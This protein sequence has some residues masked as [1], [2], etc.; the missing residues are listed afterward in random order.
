MSQA[1]KRREALK[2]VVFALL[3]GAITTGIISL[4]LISINLGFSPEFF[5]TWLK[6]WLMAYMFV[7]PAILFIAPGVEKLVNRIL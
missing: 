6:S 1:K 7:I 3:M 2:K 4:A 5:A